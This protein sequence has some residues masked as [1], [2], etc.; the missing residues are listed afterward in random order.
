MKACWYS[1][2]VMSA[3]SCCFLVAL[4]MLVPALSGC[5]GLR[6]KAE[7]KPVTTQVEENFKHRWVEKRSAEIAGQGIAQD[8]ARRRALTEFREKYEYTGAALE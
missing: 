2:V 4:L 5:A 6:K 1:C 3:K 8:E 7:E